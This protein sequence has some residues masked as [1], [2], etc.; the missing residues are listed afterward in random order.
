VWNGTPHCGAK[1]PGIERAL[2]TVQRFSRKPMQYA[3]LQ[4][5]WDGKMSVSRV[6]E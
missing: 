2:Q 6:A 5:P 4:P 3:A 1:G